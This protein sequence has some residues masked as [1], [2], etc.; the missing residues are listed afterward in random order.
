MAYV[1]KWFPKEKQGTALGIFGAGNVGAAVTKFAAPVIMV[2]YGWKDGGAGLGGRARRDRGHFLPDDQGR[3]RSGPP[4][5]DWSE[6]EPLSA[7]MEPLKN[8][9][10][11]RFSL[12]YFFV[13]G[14]FVALALWLPRYL[15]GVYNLDIATAGM[16]GAAYSIPASIFRAYG[17]H[18]SDKYGARTIMYWTFGVSVIC[19]FRAVLPAD[20]LRHSGHSWAGRVLDAHGPLWLYRRRLRARLLHE[21]RQG[22]RVQ[23]HPGL[24]PDASERSAVSS[25]SW[26]GWAALFC[27]LPSAC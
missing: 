12:Y 13:F 2:A 19:T 8:I 1:S 7:M 9:Q 15:M 5:R 20:I 27:R 3:P 18:L 26:A 22:G 16:I 21:P 23:A 14:A 17:G 25:A 6:A 24:L 11:W 10:V 4:P